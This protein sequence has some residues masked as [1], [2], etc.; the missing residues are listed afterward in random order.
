MRPRAKQGPSAKLTGG[1]ATR[2]LHHLRPVTARLPRLQASAAA[3]L[4]RLGVVAAMEHGVQQLGSQAVALLEASVTFR[5]ES[6]KLE[7][8]RE[9]G[10]CPSVFNP[11][12]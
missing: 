2:Q 12:H 11:P 9:G 1:E 3:T 5:C 6:A 7:Y 10:C 4:Q 8:L